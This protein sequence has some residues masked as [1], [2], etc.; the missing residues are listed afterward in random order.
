[1]N[2]EN[3]QSPVSVADEIRRLLPETK[4]QLGL[5][6]VC[7]RDGITDR[8]AIVAA[9]ASA[10]TGAVGNIL[11]N[12]RAIRD[13]EVPRA[14]SMARNA[15]SATRSFLNQHRA[16]LSDATILHLQS[17]IARLEEA[18]A[19]ESAQ[20]EEEDELKAKGDELEHALAIEGGVYVYTFPQYWRYPTVAGTKR[21][22]LKIGM[23]TRDATSRVREQARGT[24]MPEEPL[25]LRVYRSKT[26]EPRAA[27]RS[28]HMLLN[29]ADHTRVNNNAGGREWFETSVEFLDTIASVLGLE[30]LQAEQSS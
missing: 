18:T 30:T 4:G 11:A 3:D 24:A 7:L 22:L 9:G 17:V 20:V 2:F 16:V 28:F 15:L 23:T 6:A 5:V 13:G 19:N 8:N 12:I 21:T 27:E 1:M 10:N 29:A 14:P 25:I 26:V